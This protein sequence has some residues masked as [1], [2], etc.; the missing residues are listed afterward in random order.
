MH[1]LRATSSGLNPANRRC[2]PEPVIVDHHK[3]VD[4][5]AFEQVQDFHGELVLMDRDRIQRHQVAHQTVG[6]FGIRLEVPHKIAMGEN[7]EQLS[8]FIG[9]N[10]GA[11]AHIGH[12][13]QDRA[14]RRIGRDQGQR[15]L[16]AA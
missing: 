12:R 8:V 2:R 15:V 3:I 9:H 13:F 10:R 7:A 4:P 5:M 1:A 16:A 11:G 6:D 14:D